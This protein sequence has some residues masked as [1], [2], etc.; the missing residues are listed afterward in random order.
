MG[1]KPISANCMLEDLLGTEFGLSSWAM[2]FI[3]NLDF[4]RG[5]GDLLDDMLTPRQ[6]EKLQEIWEE[7]YR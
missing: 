7:S 1:A 6:L 4:R 2:D 5:E 3:G